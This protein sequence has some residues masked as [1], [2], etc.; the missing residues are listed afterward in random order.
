MS[1]AVRM[2][3][4]QHEVRYRFLAAWGLEPNGVKTAEDFEKMI[5]EAMRHDDARF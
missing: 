5:F 2:R 1:Y 3:M 4:E